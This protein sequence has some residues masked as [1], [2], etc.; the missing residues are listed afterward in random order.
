MDKEQY[1]MLLELANA[2]L[3]PSRDV[4]TTE[5]SEGLMDT[6]GDRYW[7][8]PLA[9]PFSNYFNE[10]QSFE[11]AVRDGDPKAV[12]PTPPQFLGRVCS[13]SPMEIDGPASQPLEPL[14]NSAL[15]AATISIETERANRR[16]T[17]TAPRTNARLGQA[18]NDLTIRL[19]IERVA[20]NQKPVYHL[21]YADQALKL[22]LPPRSQFSKKNAPELARALIKYARRMLANEQLRES[23]GG[24]EEGELLV[25]QLIAYM[26]RDAPFND[27]CAEPLARLSWWKA[28]MNDPDA[29]QLAKLGIKLF[30]VSPSEMCDERTASK[31][32]AWSTAK[33]NGLSADYIINMGILE[34]YWKYSF[35]NSGIYTHTSRLSLDNFDGDT[36]PPTRTLPAPSLQDL[37]NPIPLDPTLSEAT[38]FSNPDPYGQA[39]LDEDEDDG[40][41]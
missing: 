15:Q 34:K 17:N 18:L 33:R 24:E 37:L 40:G 2:F 1:D 25:K 10:V 14:S 26:Y 36:L 16:I 29:T 5:L 41:G 12:K 28:K 8:E 11:L 9:T 7:D 21:Y 20:P 19:L 39:A 4:S 23:A 13:E 35:N 3:Q 6:F 38:L 27:L 22:N 32:A 31:M 30:S